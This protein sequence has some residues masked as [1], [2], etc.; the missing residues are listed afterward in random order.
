MQKS[1]RARCIAAL[2]ALAALT[3][4]PAVRAGDARIHKWVD[5]KGV[6][7]YGDKIPARDA[8]RDNE[9]LN[10]QGVVIERRRP[11]EIDDKQA[12]PALLEQ[13][14]RDRTLRASY[15]DVGEIDLARDRSL[16]MD[17]AALQALDQRRSA[18]NSRKDR[19]RQTIDRQRQQNKPVAADL[20]EDL[21]SA[22][23]ELESVEQQR[24]QRMQR[25]ETTRQRFARDRQRYIELKQGAD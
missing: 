16:Q 2:I 11:G 25:M 3:S 13:Q 24:A 4:G 18:I 1:Y 21:R 7:H 5:E 15:T 22:E 10:R 8:G 12:D 23:T 14:R 9:L 20:T 17:E 6:T 19:L